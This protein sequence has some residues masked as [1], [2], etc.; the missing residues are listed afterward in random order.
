MINNF[1]PALTLQ[2]VNPKLGAHDAIDHA[3][4]SRAFAPLATL[5]NAF[6]GP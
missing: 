6:V 4:D 2:P 5:V 1:E 3:P